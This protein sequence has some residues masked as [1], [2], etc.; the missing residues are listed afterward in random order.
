MQQNSLYIS[1]SP[2]EQPG[3]HICENDVLRQQFKSSCIVHCLE[4]FAGVCWGLVG[5]A[6]VCYGLL[7]STWQLTNATCKSND[8]FESSA[9]AWL[10][11]CRWS[12][13]AMVSKWKSLGKRL[14]KET[15]K[16][17]QGSTL[18]KDKLQGLYTTGTKQQTLPKHDWSATCKLVEIRVCV[19]PGGMCKESSLILRPLI[20]E[21]LILRWMSRDDKPCARI[22]FPPPSGDDYDRMA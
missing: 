9:N 19:G 15:A 20:G 8:P 7:Q 10:H 13:Q 5:F 3:C 11:N 21:S 14:I 1:S 18:C 6:R 22:A 16:P 2:A 17:I 12:M 4:C